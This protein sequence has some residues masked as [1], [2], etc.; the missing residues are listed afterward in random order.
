MIEF[1]KAFGERLRNLRE[2]KGMSR[3]EL[4][5]LVGLTASGVGTW[6]RG[7]RSPGN[8][9]TVELARLFEVST[10]Y[11]LTGYRAEAIELGRQTGLSQAAI[12]GFVYACKCAPAFLEFLFSNPGSVFLWEDMDDYLRRAVKHE[13]LPAEKRA[14][15]QDPDGGQVFDLNWGLLYRSEAKRL[16]GAEIEGY[17]RKEVEKHAQKKDNP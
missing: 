6:E 12:D 14:V 2:A 11:L 10:D 15:V 13:L 4:G 16:M 7:E 5:R 17:V 9:L 8:E 3:E 1:D